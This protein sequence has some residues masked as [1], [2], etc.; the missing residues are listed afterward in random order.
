MRQHLALSG[1]C[2]HRRLSSLTLL[3]R[4]QELLP[5]LF[6]SDTLFGTLYC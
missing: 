5:E 6:R 4:S 3:Q 2:S 1:L